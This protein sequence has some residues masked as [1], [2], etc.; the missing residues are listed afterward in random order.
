MANCTQCGAELKSGSRFCAECGAAVGVV[1]SPVAAEPTPAPTSAPAPTPAAPAPAPQPVTQPQSIPQPPKAAPAQ[2]RPAYTP[3][4]PAYTPPTAGET[5]PPAGSKYELISTGG[6]IGIMLLMCIP[7]VGLILMIVWACGGCRKIQ[8]RNLARAGLIMMV[9]SVILG[10]I[11]GFA[12]KALINSAMKAAGIDPKAGTS[13]SDVLLDK[14]AGADSGESGGLLSGLL[15]IAA[16]NDGAEDLSE[17]EKMFKD[18]EGLTGGEFDGDELLDEIGEVNAEAARHS[19]GWPSDLP[20]FPGG[21]MVAVADYRT[22]FTDTTLEQTKDYI[23]MLK[24]EGFVYQDF[25]DF[26]MSEADMMEFGGWWGSNGK[27]YLSVSFSEGTTLID[28]TTELPDM[29]ELL[30]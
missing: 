3:P 22:E 4:P 27:W 13:L 18:L 30:G 1:A 2:G 20:D 5:P 7:V 6:F 11:I 9:I 8:K 19:D 29:S 21:T 12:A 10:L 26:G 15:G 16:G 24:D 23:Q 25:Y 17:L 28:H 14:D